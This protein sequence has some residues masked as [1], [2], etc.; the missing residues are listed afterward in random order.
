MS[1]WLDRLR[2]CE[3]NK[4]IENLPMSV[5][6]V[7][8][9]G[10]QTKF[11]DMHSKSDFETFQPMSVMSVLDSTF[12]NKKNKTENILKDTYIPTDKTDI[13]SIPPNVHQRL[14]IPPLWLN[15]VEIVL[16]REKPQAIAAK[17]WQDITVRLRMLVLEEREPFYK[18]VKYDWPLQEVFGCH[19]FAPD[20]RIDGMGLLM[21]ITTSAIAEIKPK[22]GFLKHKDG[23]ITTYDL[24]MLNHNSA[25]QSTLM[26][27]E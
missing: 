25:E 12:E 1:Q 22:G 16:K 15:A 3:K 24:D 17:R 19:K 23:A 13:G 10:N 5:L 2:E 21:L 18:I 26:E 20:V 9:S 7:S 27:I 11:S 8:H 14:E 4:N 6:S